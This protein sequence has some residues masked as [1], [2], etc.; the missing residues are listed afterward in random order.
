M[1]HE[2]FKELC[3]EY[4]GRVFYPNGDLAHAGE[5][6]VDN[7]VINALAASQLDPLVEAL[8]ELVAQFGVTELPS[9]QRYAFHG[10]LN[11]AQDALTKAKQVQE[12]IKEERG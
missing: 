4:L 8:D 2:L 6:I 7:G 1:F 9:H 10:P 11:Q 3:P 5:L 12:A